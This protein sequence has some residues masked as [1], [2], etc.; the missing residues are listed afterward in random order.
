MMNTTLRLALVLLF[1]LGLWSGCQSD[2]RVIAD[3]SDQSYPLVN[4]DS[5]TVTFP[6]AFKGK[7]LVVGTIYTHCPDICSMITANMKRA[8]QQ[9]ESAEDVQFV[10]ITF[11]PRRDTPSRLTSYRRS[12]DVDGTSWAFLTGS[13]DTVNALME[14]LGIFHQ[15]V[16]PDGSPASPDTL[17]TYFISHSDRILFVDAEGQV[18]PGMNGS[19][20]PPDTLVQAIN[21]LRSWL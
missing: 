14:E 16:G 5:S 7:V 10:T 13:P 4:Q 19:R 8:R 20:T 3:L 12:F 11:D 1:G 18:H 2:S 9:L 21:N 17:D 15:V 6:D